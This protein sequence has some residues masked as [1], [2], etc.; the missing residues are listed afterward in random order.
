VES[1]AQL[2]VRQALSTARPGRSTSDALQSNLQAISNVERVRFY[3]NDSAI[4]DLN[5]VPA[6]AFAAVVDG[7]DSTAIAQA[8]LIGKGGAGTYGTTSVSVPDAYGIA[9]TV[10][11]FRPT[12]P[13]ITYE[14]DIVPLD[15]YSGDVDTAIAQAVS[16]WTNALG[17]GGGPSGRIRLPRVYGPALLTGTIYYDTFEI[18]GIKAARDGQALTT[19]DVIMLFNEAPICDPSDVSVVKP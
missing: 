16:I 12:V 18:V 5:G 6:G 2:R 17:I 7:G 4:T 10:C 15:G 11:F 1:D 14:I 9:R 3:E 8:I 19:A 13:R